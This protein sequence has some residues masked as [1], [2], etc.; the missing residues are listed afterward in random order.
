M[1]RQWASSPIV[2]KAHTADTFSEC[3]AMKMKTIQSCETSGSHQMQQYI[4]GD[5]NAQQHHC[6]NLKFAIYYGLICFSF[7]FSKIKDK[8]LHP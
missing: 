7:S 8:C 5:F 3:L 1:L 2:S 6:E 4:S